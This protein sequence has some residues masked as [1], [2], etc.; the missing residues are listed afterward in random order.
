MEIKG[1][2]YQTLVIDHEDER[3]ALFTA[4]N[5]DLGDFV[6]KQVKF[7]QMKKDAVLGGH[8]HD[9]DELFYMLSGE[10]EFTLKDPASK[11]MAEFQL[12]KG[13]RLYIPSGIAHKALIKAQSLL[14]GCTAEPYISPEH[15]DRKYDF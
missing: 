9:Y 10:G 15:N 14:V 2:V 5:G 4:F 8:F 11:I 6:A 13:D 1:V 7:A 12:V 3:R